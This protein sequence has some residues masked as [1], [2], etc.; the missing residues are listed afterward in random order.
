MPLSEFR[1]ISP[2]SDAADE[3]TPWHRLGVLGG[4]NLVRNWSVRFPSG[5]FG[6]KGEFERIQGT[7]VVMGEMGHEVFYLRRLFVRRLEPDTLKSTHYPGFN[8]GQSL[9]VGG[10]GVHDGERFLYICPGRSKRFL[11]W[12]IPKEVPQE[13][14]IDDRPPKNEP[15][16]EVIA[17]MPEVIGRSAALTHQG[18]FV[19]ALRGGATR[20]FW[21]YSCEKNEWE[22]LAPLPNAAIAPGDQGAGLTSTASSVFAVSGPDVWRYDLNSKTWEHYS[23]MSFAM[24]WDGGMVAGDGDNAMYVI[25]GGVSTLLGRVDYATGR[26]DDLFPRL[27]EVVSAEGNRACVMTIEGERRLYIHRGHN[28]NETLW[29]PLADLGPR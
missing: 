12:D 18:G 5:P 25:R 23:E 10:A 8:L 27:P 29:V 2:T 11:R 9:A 1:R 28:S 3:G 15:E 22:V 17:D 4:G 13:K 21:R 19:Y 24:D 14:R 7:L 20:D 26:F 6:P 16:I